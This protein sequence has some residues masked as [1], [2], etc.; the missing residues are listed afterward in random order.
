M[1]KA[2]STSSLKGFFLFL[3]VLVALVAGGIGLGS[4][5]FG[6]PPKKLYDRSTPEDVLAAAKDMVVNN[7]AERL[8][9]LFYADDDQM[10]ELYARLGLVLGHIQDL[11]VAINERF[12]DEVAEA[13]ATAEAAAKSGKGMSLLEQFAPNARRRRDGPP[14]GAEEDRWNQLLQTIASDPYAWLTDAE[15]RL[16]FTYL[17][18]ERVA[19]LWDKKPVLPPLGLVLRREEGQWSVVLPLATLPMA[20]RFMPQT[21]DE[22][23]IWGSLIQ[24]ADNVVIDLDKDVREGRLTTLDSLARTAGEKAAPPMLMGMIAY[25]KAL[26]ERR[27]RERAAKAAASKPAGDG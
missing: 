17:D 20:S 9:E 10:R 5:F 1:D 12:P 19:V 3:G 13:R 27:R 24:M 6:P 16:T 25:N 2:S 11:A 18:D 21:P 15:G 4:V 14:S 23:S 7:E 22:Y 8:S 26:E